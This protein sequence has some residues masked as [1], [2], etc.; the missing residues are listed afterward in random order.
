MWRRGDTN[1]ELNAP[2]GLYNGHGG[3]AVASDMHEVP[4][5]IAYISL[6]MGT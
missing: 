2:F 3:H 6:Y 5:H 1:F 4:C